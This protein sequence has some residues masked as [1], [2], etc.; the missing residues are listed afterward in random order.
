MNKA[1]TI[2]VI[3]EGK[4]ENNFVNEVLAP[5]WSSR[6]IYVYAPVIRTG[7]DKKAGVIYTG[8]D[9][10]FERIK[11]RVGEFLQQRPD[12]LVATFVDFYGIKTWPGLELVQKN[13]TP[14]QIASRLNS[15][16]YEIMAGEFAEWHSSRRYV[17]FIA[18]HEFEA[19]LFSDASILAEKLAIPLAI[20]ED[21]LAKSGSPEAIDNSPQ[22][23][24]SKRL[25][26]WTNGMYGKTSDS[27]IIAKAI[28]IDKM[29]RACPNFDA[30]LTSIESIQTEE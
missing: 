17:P 12:I 15:A 27:L 14:E 16:A 9:I 23:A 25:E 30:W 20:I 19:L 10:R 26:K 13:D 1:L 5:Y 3:V 28:G 11:K 6:E 4:T 22:T 21:T 7:E 8:G 2:E 24:P 29:R 18:V